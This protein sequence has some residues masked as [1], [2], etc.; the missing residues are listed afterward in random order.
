ML[1]HAIRVLLQPLLST[2]IILRC[3]RLLTLELIVT[4]VLREG[5]TLDKTRQME[6]VIFAR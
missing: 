5:T 1:D 2:G 4:E 3:L 6:I